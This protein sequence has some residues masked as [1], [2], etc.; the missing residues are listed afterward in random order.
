MLAWMRRRV[1]RR[2]GGDEESGN[3]D[4]DKILVQVHGILEQV[5]EIRVSKSLAE[6]R[7]FASV[8]EL[9]GKVFN[10]D[11]F[12]Q[13]SRNKGPLPTSPGIVKPKSTF[14]VGTRSHPKSV[15]RWIY[16]VICVHIIE[17]PSTGIGFPSA[18]KSDCSPPLGVDISANQEP[19]FK[20]LDQSEALAGI[21]FQSAVTVVL[22]KPSQ[23]LRDS[24][25][26]N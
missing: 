24:H 5:R 7:K 2:T 16:P 17:E 12:F 15:K 1:E 19:G 18:A 23:T 13:I 25:S 3:A 22:N 14:N 8:I 4:V 9:G 26:Y 21:G 20:S 11:S 10:S 6:I